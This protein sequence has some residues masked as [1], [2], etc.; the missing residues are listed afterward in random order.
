[1]GADLLFIMSRSEAKRYMDLKYV[2]ADEG[3]DVILDRREGERRRSQG[4][5]R[6]ERR[7][8]ERRHR[9][10][11][12]ELQLYGW[13]LV[14]RTKVG[15]RPQVES[16]GPRESD[17]RGHKAPHLNDYLDSPIS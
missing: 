15:I 11:T 6:T 16:A 12:R 13:T 7:R 17:G 10:T 9:D 3:R 5:P 14:R 1:M 2:Y 4:Q 8:V